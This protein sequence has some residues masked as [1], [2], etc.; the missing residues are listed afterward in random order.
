[1]GLMIEATAIS[2][3][4]SP[5]LKVNLIRTCSWIGYKRWKEF[6]F[7][8]ISDGRKV[9]LVALKLRKYASIWWSNVVTERVRKGKGK[10]RT[11]EKM[12]SKLKSKFLPPHLLAR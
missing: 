10:I 12:K 3:W 1:M 7:K 8:D 5:N 4:T 2:K 9:K 11:R 6:E